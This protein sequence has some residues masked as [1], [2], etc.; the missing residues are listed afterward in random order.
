MIGRASANQ[1]VL[2]HDSVSRRHALIHLQAGNE[3]WLVDLGSSN[4]TTLNKR[5]VVQP[6]RLKNGDH[7]CVGS[8]PL[9]FISVSSP[10]AMDTMVGSTLV[11]LKVTRQ[12]LLIADIKGF[13]PLSQQLSPDELAKTIGSWFS[14]TRKILEKH[15]GDIHKY[16][17]D[18]WLAGW[19]DDAG[20]NRRVARCIEAL[21][22]LQQTSIPSFRLAL[23]LGEVTSSGSSTSPDLGMFGPDVNFLFR[24][25]KIGAGLT[26][27]FVS[28]KTA[29]KAL[30]GLRPTSSAGRHVLKGFPGKH[31]LFV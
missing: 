28:S 24:M 12:W 3:Y 27:P 4:G 30:G 22:T 6:V 25:E 16:L 7:L 1:L 23:H 26:A 11:N 18:G 8:V 14:S 20:A 19:F 9:T 10:T 31:E 21:G 13:T 29:A 17:G 15:G 2:A 5:P